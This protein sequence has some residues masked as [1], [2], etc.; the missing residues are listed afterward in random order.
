M[1][2]LVLRMLHYDMEQITYGALNARCWG[3]YS[4][5]PHY[6]L[7]LQVA[8]GLACSYQASE[9]LRPLTIQQQSLSRRD[10]V[11]IVNLL[12]C[13]TATQR[14][15]DNQVKALKNLARDIVIEQLPL[16]W[17][18]KTFL[19][20]IIIDQGQISPPAIATPES[21]S[22]LPSTPPTPPFIPDPLPEE[23]RT[24]RRRRQNHMRGRQT[25]PRPII[26]PLTPSTS[27]RPQMARRREGPPTHS[28]H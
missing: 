13:T 14:E 11:R 6:H 12:S 9:N 24:T 7:P 21:R 19:D 23:V 17:E 26:P 22:P 8:S 3:M 1:V 10:Q 20:N 28:L 4:D 16:G 5:P 27:Q 25:A 2:D 18:E 15:L